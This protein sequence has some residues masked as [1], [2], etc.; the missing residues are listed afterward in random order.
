VLGVFIRTV[1]RSLRHRAK[2]LLGADQGQ[3][4][5]VTH[6][7]RW[8]GAIN[9]NLHFHSIFLD[10]VYTD[11]DNTEKPVFFPLPP[12]DDEGIA[13]VAADTARGIIRLLER[14]G[15]LSDL[16]D[17]AKDALQDEEPLL[18]ACAAASLQHRIATG[19]RTGKPVM[20]LGDRIEAE[21]VEFSP[22]KSCAN[23]Q[24]FS[25][26][27][28]VAINAHDRARLERLARY[29]IRPPTATQRLSE[30]ADGRI[31]RASPLGEMAPPMSYSRV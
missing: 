16:G 12:P 31:L 18:A 24:G 8:G 20:R 13:R 19:D 2:K 4:D 21:D 9:L 25:L 30:L 6:I 11:P 15:L 3:S 10:G 1:L 5:S 26:H 22:G 7:Q 29:I 28:G 27:A 17:A 14:R 23:V